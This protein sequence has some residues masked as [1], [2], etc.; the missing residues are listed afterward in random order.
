MSKLSP[1]QEAL[2]KLHEQSR[3]VEEATDRV[4]TLPLAEKILEDMEVKML[5]EFE[6]IQNE[7]TVY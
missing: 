1:L 4:I 5:K 2:K 7:N 6:R 3:E